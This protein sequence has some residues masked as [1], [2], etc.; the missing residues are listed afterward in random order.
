MSTKRGEEEEEGTMMM[1]ALLLLASKEGDSTR[2]STGHTDLSWFARVSRSTTRITGGL[3]VC[4]LSTSLRDETVGSTKQGKV[5]SALEKRSTR[6][7]FHISTELIIIINI[8]SHTQN[9]LSQQQ[10][11]SFILH[12]FSVAI[13]PIASCITKRTS[14]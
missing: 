6:T 2:D 8:P 5:R 1:K 10:Q 9:I 14:E 13:I 7:Q 3:V 11:P 12:S 4:R